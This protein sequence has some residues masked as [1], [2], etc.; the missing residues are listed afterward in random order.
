MPEGFADGG[1]G[2]SSG[3]GDV[4][5]FDSGGASNGSAASVA[6]RR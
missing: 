2:A 3:Y 5:Q 6:A 4:P 1:G